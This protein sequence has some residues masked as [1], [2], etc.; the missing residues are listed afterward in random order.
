[1][2]R[3]IDR[4]RPALPT[5][6]AELPPG[7]TDVDRVERLTTPAAAE[8]FEHIG[9]SFG[10][11]FSPD[12]ESIMADLTTLGGFDLFHVLHR[13]E[14]DRKLE[15]LLD[16]LSPDERQQLISRLVAG[17]L[18]ERRPPPDDRL[19][20]KFALPEPLRAMLAELDALYARKAPAPTR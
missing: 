16:Q 15:P 13:L 14:R 12:M 2:P 6:P 3:P 17:G 11:G 5:E 4:A 1:M 19:D 9:A 7:K 10:W 8:A 18:V 20:E